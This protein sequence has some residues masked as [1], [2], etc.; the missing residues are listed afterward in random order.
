[1][2]RRML[3]QVTIEVVRKLCGNM[4]LATKISNLLAVAYVGI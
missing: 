1:M 2:I 3:S 4:I